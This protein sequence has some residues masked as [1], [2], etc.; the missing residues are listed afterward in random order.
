M[1]GEVV[2]ELGVSL[3]VGS[4]VGGDVGDPLCPTGIGLTPHRLDGIQ[5]QDVAGRCALGEDETHAGEVVLDLTVV[6]I[7]GRLVEDGGGVVAL[8]LTLHGVPG[9]V[10]A[11]EVDAEESLP[12]AHGLVSL[13]VE[14]PAGTA[15]Q[16]GEQPLLAQLTGGGGQLL[17]DPVAA[18]MLGQHVHAGVAHVLVEAH[19]GAVGDGLVHEAVLVEDVTREL[20]AVVVAPIVEGLGE[21][22]QEQ[23]VGQVDVVELDGGHDLAVL[24]VEQLGE[25]GTAGKAVAGLELLEDVV[26]PGGGAGHNAVMLAAVVEAVTAVRLVGED[27]LDASAEA[28]AATLGVL[29]VGHL[30]ELIGGLAAHGIDVGGA[31]VVGV[32]RVGHD[33]E[34]QSLPLTGLVC[35]GLGQ[36]LDGGLHGASRALAAGDGDGVQLLICIEVET[37]QLGYVQGKGLIVP[38]HH[39]GGGLVDVQGLHAVLGIHGDLTAGRAGGPTILV[40][41]PGLHAVLLGGIGHLVDEV[42][43]LIPQV[44]GDESR[45]GVHEVAAQSHLLHDVGLA[46]QLLAAKLAVPGPEGLAAVLHR[47]GGK[48]LYNLLSFHFR[49]PIRNNPLA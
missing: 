32:G 21:A 25:D 39:V 44:L 17:D 23:G 42:E 9:Q 47:G 48:I 6:L 40:V 27:T 20:D 33:G 28:V 16:L 4:H 37:V 35:G 5:E 19:E 12:V 45:A 18:V 46:H 43:P 29:L 15:V 30:D 8:G 49:S 1:V 13:E 7:P 31:V 34:A 2:E 3:L 11:T 10:L 41:E 14:L 36:L 24:T 38:V 26:R 22:L